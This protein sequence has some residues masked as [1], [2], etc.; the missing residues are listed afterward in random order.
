MQK[1]RQYGSRTI[2]VKKSEL[3]QKLKTNKENHIKE[4]EKAV[5]AYKEEALRQLNDQIKKVEEGE[6]NAKLNLV[7]PI[8]NA[9]NYDKI[10]EMFEWEVEEVVVLEQK[11]FIEYVQDETEFA[12]NA[13]F[14]N[15]MYSMH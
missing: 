8:N 9:A 10:I 6:L 1:M 14:S 2:N 4:Y 7:T 13:K 12:L 5:I 11:E 15:T 3:I